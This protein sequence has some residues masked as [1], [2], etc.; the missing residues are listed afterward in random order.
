MAV[1]RFHV[2]A[3]S[4]PLESTAMV[5]ARVPFIRGSYKDPLSS[6]AGRGSIQVRGD[7]D[8]LTEVVDP[9]NNVET[10]LRIYQNNVV[11]GSFFAT[12]TAKELR[13]DAA[14]TVTITGR[15][16]SHIPNDA[17]VL[18]FDYPDTPTV[19]PDWIWGNGADINGFR[20]GSFE[21]SEEVPDVSTYDIGTDFEDGSLQGWLATRSFLP[22]FYENDATV[23]VNTDDAQAGSYSMEVNAGVAYSGFRKQIR[24]QGG[25]TY[26]FTWYMKSATTGKHVVGLLDLA[27]GTAS[28]T[29][30]YTINGRTYAE[31]G[32][33]AQDT[34]TTDGT[35]QQLTITVAYPTFNAGDP[36]QDF[37]DV[38]LYA[39]YDDTGNGPLI[40]LDSFTASGPGLGLAPWRRYGSGVTTFE[41]DATPGSTSPLDGSQSAAV[42]T[43]NALEGI[44]QKVEGLTV[45][46]TYT[47]T[48]YVHHT[49]G[50]DQDLRVR[51]RRG[52]GDGI[53]ALAT[54]TV[55]TGGGWTKVSVTTE[56][57]Q[58]TVLV[59]VLKVTAGTFWVDKCR[60]QEGSGSATIG[61]MATAL[62]DDLTVDHVGEVSAFG[63]NA[64]G[65][66]TPTTYLDYSTHSAT[67]DAAGD[68][69]EPAAVSGLVEY[70]ATR[71]KKLSHV[72]TDWARMGFEYRI[73]D[74]L[75]TSVD[76]ELYN[77]YDWTTRTGGVGS[78]LVGTGVKELTYGAGVTGGPFVQQ[79]A[80]VN[81]VLVEGD[82][83]RWTVRRD[84]TQEAAVGTRM[85]WEGNRNYLG[86]DTL[87]QIAS[88]ILDERT[89]P[90]TALKLKLEPKD[91]S[92]LP[93]PY[94]DFQVGDTYPIN[95]TGVFVG[96]KRVVEVTTD[97]TEG[98]G[99][100]EV[101]FDQ[102]TYT[103]DPSKAMAEAV[104]RLLERFDQ[105]DA[106]EDLSGPSPATDDTSPGPIEPSYLIA[107]ANTRPA[108][109]DVA[110]FVCSGT[111][112]GDTFT[113]ATDALAA[114]PWGGG[115]LVLAAGDYYFTTPL[116]LSG[117]SYM[118]LHG[119]GV[120]S[121]QL[122]FTLAGAETACVA[123][124]E[125]SIIDKMS[126][127]ELDTE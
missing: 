48:A 79:P 111:N 71:G 127:Y 62:L 117:F 123:M 49:T 59:D 60:F 22:G 61:T 122:Y 3:W 13:G 112:D 96:A 82:D 91:D 25:E 90:S 2:E 73:V 68:P 85:V 8:R 41:Q 118:W 88:T 44:T 53:V 74:N 116:D 27:G 35:W 6:Q 57:D 103:S 5:V 36:E 97:F 39:I 45:A 42:V 30:A 104:R 46:R 51:I 69:W 4:L 75:P 94:V 86:D 40:R 110:D 119:M 15:A 20:N 80:A 67:V 33:A 125:Y 37:K 102:E 52:S 109:Q 78:N 108:V 18:N 50:S 105:L 56:I 43:S 121:T 31:L 83:G 81:R 58:E 14:G 55:S 87:G 99:S 21:E 34:G 93:I 1:N 28:H 29:N 101:E 106:P 98:Y 95:L 120:E 89:T 113:L 126:I 92:T 124:G 32:N 23:K 7:W 9:G 12:R 10:L 115:R 64:Y 107:S 84:A 77:P 66:L 38:W 100:Y 24:V 114:S 47:F 65:S 26:T 19:D 72:F 16:L 63:V 54:E 17:R 11:V 76:L 70:R